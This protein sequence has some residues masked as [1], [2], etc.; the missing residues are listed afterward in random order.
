MTGNLPPQ[1]SPDSASPAKRER[2]E[3]MASMPLRRG[4]CDWCGGRCPKGRTYCCS[5]C[6]ERY[7]ALLTRQGKALVQLLKQ[8]RMHR[9]RV[10]TP[11]A[12]KLTLVS[13]RV[14]LLLTEDRQRWADLEC[15]RSK[16]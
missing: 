15:C 6:R 14:D 12:G 8:W 5:E 4:H 9:G 1:I 7:N 13:S 10:G 2:L 11:G 16:E 3:P